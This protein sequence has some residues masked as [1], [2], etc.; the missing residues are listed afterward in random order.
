MALIGGYVRWRPRMVHQSVLSDLKTTLEAL[1]WY[2]TGAPTTIPVPV[3]GLLTGPLVLQDAFPEEGIYQGQA[4]V[5]NTL[6]MDMGVPGEIELGELGG[7]FEQPYK[8]SFA[9][10]AESDAVAKAVLSDLSDRY[11]GITASPFIT[12]QNYAVTPVTDIVRI[13]VDSFLYAP[14]PDQVAPGE[15]HLYFAEMTL[16]DYIEQVERTL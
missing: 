10:F 13:E 11:L 6:A 1:D 7:Y 16:T 8:F 2:D 14:N 5:K 12:L 3:A 9:F 4:P 15:H